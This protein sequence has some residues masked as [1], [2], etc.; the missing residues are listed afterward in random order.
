MPKLPGISHDRAV[1]AFKKKGFWIERE[2]K[3]TF[4]TDGE[5]IAVIPRHN[6][7]KAVTMG[8]IV[9]QA[10]MTIEEFKKLL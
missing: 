5:Y 8:A 7:I 9:R 3:H 2:S 1:R 6:P 10:G 4:M